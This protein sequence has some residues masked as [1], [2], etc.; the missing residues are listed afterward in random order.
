M[1]SPAGSPGVCP[2]SPRA[3]IFRFHLCS[4]P[5]T[6]PRPHRRLLMSS[7][8]WRLANAPSKTPRPRWPRVEPPP[9]GSSWR[10]AG[11]GG[12]KPCGKW[13]F[14]S[15]ESRASRG[16]S[17]GLPRVTSLRIAQRISCTLHRATQRM[18]LKGWLATS[19]M[20]LA[21][22]VHGLPWFCGG[23]WFIL[24]WCATPS[25]VLSSRTVCHALALIPF[26]PGFSECALVNVRLGC[27]S[28]LSFV[29]C[30]F[31]L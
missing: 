30:C 28:P 5:P 4:A 17:V 24:V 13:L 20:G 15:S 10:R 6:S 16:V 23:S 7:M 2:G 1:P 18:A 21:G 19:L 8:E 11:E 25:C 12:P 3:W 22:E 14:G 27:R 26:V 31:S 9:A 29:G